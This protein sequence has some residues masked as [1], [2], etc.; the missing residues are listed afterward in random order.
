MAIELM[1]AACGRKGPREGFI[2]SFCPA[3]FTTKYT[4]KASKTVTITRCV[5]CRKL[6]SGGW[7]DET[8]LV[9]VLRD[10][11]K[12]EHV[13]LLNEE[14]AMMTVNIQGNRINVPVSIKYDDTIC[15]DCTRRTSGYFEAILQL[16][17]DFEK[18]APKIINMLREESFVRKID[19]NR[20]GMD[21]YVG[22]K[23]AV[24]RVLRNMKLKPLKSYKLHGQKQ[25]KRIYR[26]TFC[27]RV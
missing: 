20:D 7:K 24:S 9:S 16:R 21:I 12:T 22:A 25:G 11:L 8:M 15:R 14:S 17:G 4:E 13:G 6:V 5:K 23:S 3:C 27:V 10:K 26:T 18:K 1:C 19:R 2:D